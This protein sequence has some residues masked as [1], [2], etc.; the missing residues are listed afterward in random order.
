MRTTLPPLRFIERVV[1]AP[2]IGPNIGKTVRTLQYRVDHEER[3]LR[4]PGGAGYSDPIPAHSTWE[5]VP[6]VPSA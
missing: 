2:E 3:R 4:L 6:L 5:D 1:P